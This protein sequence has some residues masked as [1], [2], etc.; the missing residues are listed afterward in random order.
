VEGKGISN[1]AGDSFCYSPLGGCRYVTDGVA[2]LMERYC[3][4]IFDSALDIANMWE[5]R[6][7]NRR[8]KTGYE[9]LM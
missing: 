7:E 6:V 5:K 3:S 9:H 4:R 1:G 8:A 2:F